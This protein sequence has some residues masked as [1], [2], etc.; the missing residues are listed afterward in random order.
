MSAESKEIDPKVD[1]A[2]VEQFVTPPVTNAIDNDQADGEESADIANPDAVAAVSSAKKKKSKKA[3]LKKAFGVGSG[4]DGGGDGS[5]SSSNPASKL[6]TGMVEQ[7]LE[8]NPSLKSEV[9]G[10]DKEKA[11]ATL[12]KLDVADLLTGMV[13]YAECL[14]VFAALTQE[15]VRERE[16][17]KGH[18]FIQILADS[19]GASIWSVSA[20]PICCHQLTIDRRDPTCRRRSN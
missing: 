14:T 11:A 10:M 18:G 2:V 3:K 12:K 6:T 1:E 17:P 5:S 8:M 15:Q 9:A 7:L 20:R 13:I 16:K 19:A 4:E